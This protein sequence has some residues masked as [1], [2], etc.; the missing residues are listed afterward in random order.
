M[1]LTTNFQK[2]EF[3]SKD[4]LP[5]PVS[6]LENIKTLAKQLQIIRD[7]I[8]LPITVSSGYRSPSHNKAV[9]GASNSQHMKGTAADIVV[10]GMRPS[11]VAAVIMRLMNQQKI[12]AGGLKAYSTWIHYDIRGGYATW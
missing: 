5:M 11:E 9:G 8:G 10:N 7:E 6:V 1:K 4:G 3:D 2:S 12:K